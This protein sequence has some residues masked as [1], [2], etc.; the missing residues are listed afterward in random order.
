MTCDWVSPTQDPNWKRISASLRDG[1]LYVK[2]P[3]TKAL[4]LVRVLINLGLDFRTKEIYE[5]SSSFVFS[6]S[7]EDWQKDLKDLSESAR[8]AMQEGATSPSSGA[9]LVELRK[10]VS[11]GLDSDPDVDWILRVNGPIGNHLEAL[12]FL[13]PSSQPESEGLEPC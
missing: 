7:I 12:E 8:I 13:T 10:S 11:K 5:N 3:K 1:K 4:T 6:G 2:M 9:I